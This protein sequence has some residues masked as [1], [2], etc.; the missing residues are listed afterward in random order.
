MDVTGNVALVTGGGRGIG[1]GICLALAN[2]GADV[3]VADLVEQGARQVA[4]EV[5]ALGRRAHAVS[6][7]VTADGPVESA[8]GDAISRL[9][10]IDILVNNA[11]SIGSAGWEDREG[12]T[13]EDWDITFGV[14]ARGTSR[15]TDAVS[16]HMKEARYGKIVN[17][18]SVA[19]RKG[20]LTSIPYGV[21]KSGV[22]SLTQAY[23]QLLAPFDINVNAICPGLLW[24]PMW[25]RIADRFRT[26]EDAEAG[27]TPRQVFDRFVKSR[28]PLG[29]E[30]TPEDVGNAAVF[31][32][33]D[34]AKNITG[35]AL[36]VCG[37][38][39]MN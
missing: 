11:G 33:S 17:I 6:M 8:V 14:N 5:E 20:T 9:G 19:G 2:N 28:T 39:L 18:A 36:N 3:V 32:A 34:T 27:R 4:A 38:Y 15:V 23:A 10:R 35:Q 13:D 1:R 31:L 29:R 25:E 22:I 12:H 21:S 16:S 24:T 26:D 7:D 30:Q 37:G